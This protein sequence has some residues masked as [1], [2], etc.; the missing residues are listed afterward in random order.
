M[1]NQDN[2]TRNLASL[3]VQDGVVLLQLVRRLIKSGVMEEQELWAVLVVRAKLVSAIQTATGVNYDVASV[4]AQFSGG[5]TQPAVIHLRHFLT[6]VPTV[7]ASPT[8]P[9]LV[10]AGAT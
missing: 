9:P 6:A 1:F 4:Q 2:I 8:M 5:P 3:I 7:A 10:S